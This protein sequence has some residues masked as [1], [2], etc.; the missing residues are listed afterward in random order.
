MGLVGDQGRAV[1]ALSV[2]DLWF[3]AREHRFDGAVLAEAIRSTFQRRGT[4][5]P[6]TTPTALTEAFAS[7]P[8][9]KTQWRAFVRK[10]R[11]PE[12]VPTL[13]EAVEAVAALVTPPVD[14][15]VAGHPFHPSREP[16]GPWR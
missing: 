3:L 7:D 11:L 6:T 1:P 16:G 4:R 2:G 12:P 13:E 8:M 10:V 14:A 9:K 15:L 5:L